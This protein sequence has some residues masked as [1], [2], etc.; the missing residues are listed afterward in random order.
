MRPPYQRFAAILEYPGPALAAELDA[1]LVALRQ[2][3]PQAA[4]P[5]EAF[6]AALSRLGLA[7][8]QEAYTAAFDLSAECALELGHQLLGEGWKR[9]AFLLRLRRLYREAGFAEGDE[10]PDHLCTL[11]RFLAAHPDRPESHEL[12]RACL[13]PALAKLRR[14]LEARSSPYQAPVASLADALGAATLEV[15][16]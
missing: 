15:A 12:A 10:L 1:C 3:R 11:L 2:R 14:A 13:V 9:T 4:E 6:A 8:L 16:G 5:L 7:G